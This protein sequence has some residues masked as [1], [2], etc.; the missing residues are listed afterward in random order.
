MNSPLGKAQPIKDGGSV[1]KKLL[2]NT[3]TAV[4]REE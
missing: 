1:S 3:A 4:E 2:H